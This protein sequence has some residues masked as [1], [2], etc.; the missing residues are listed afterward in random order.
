MFGLFKSKTVG[1]S[2]LLDKLEEIQDKM[3]DAGVFGALKFTHEVFAKLDDPKLKLT[4]EQN[5]SILIYLD[6]IDSHIGN[7]YIELIKYECAE[8]IFRSD[9][10]AVI[11]DKNDD[12]KTLE[13]RELK[14]R[15]ELAVKRDYLEAA[16]G[17]GISEL[18]EI[19]LQGEIEELEAKHKKYLEDY[20]AK[21]KE[22]Y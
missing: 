6:E 14:T 1:V 9:R 20:Q 16:K 4:E 12:L 17:S 8:I 19:K 2:P 21:Q 13:H 18:E 22:Q 15:I 7:E 11:T 10:S 3:R 5:R